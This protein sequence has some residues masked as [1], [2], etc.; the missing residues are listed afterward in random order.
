[1][2]VQRHRSGRSTLWASCRRAL[3]ALAMVVWIAG[4]AGAR[5]TGD[6]D[7]K[8]QPVTFADGYLSVNASNTPMATVLRNIAQYAGVQIEVYGE[9]EM[10]ISMQFEHLPLDDALH[11]LLGQYNLVLLYKKI[12]DPPPDGPP[13]RL[14]GVQIHVEPGLNAPTMQ[15]EAGRLLATR[16]RL[17]RRKRK[18]ANSEERTS[19]KLAAA[20]DEDSAAVLARLR[21][22]A[23]DSDPAVRADAVDEVTMIDDEKAAADILER[24]LREDSDASVRADAMSGLEDLEKP[25][26]ETVLDAVLFDEAP[27][28]RIG[29]IEII[30]EHEWKDQRTVDTLSRVLDDPNEEIR[31]SALEV[32][33]ELGQKSALESAARSSPHQDVRELAA[34]LLSEL[35]P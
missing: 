24:V 1:M 16:K 13:I 33:G 27:D 29:A 23:F 26:M 15:F 28:V 20:P 31:A 5:V 8:N 19:D 11:R 18:G 3:P 6:A 9:P 30:E 7:A 14:T 32:L 10:T 35:Q 25:P 2:N 17:A 4:A 22:A 34:E 21:T 12:K